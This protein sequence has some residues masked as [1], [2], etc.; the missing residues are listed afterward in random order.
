MKTAGTAMEMAT[1]LAWKQSGLV[2]KRLGIV[3]M[4]GAGASV[5]ST[6]G[7]GAGV[8]TAGRQQG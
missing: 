5:D 3:H 2:L 4:A 1:T 6:A 8:E 7:D